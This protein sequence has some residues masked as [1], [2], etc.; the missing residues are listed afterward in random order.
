MNDINIVVERILFFYK[1]KVEK[2]S[3][4]TIMFWRVSLCYTII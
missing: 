1:L 4:S 3:F 2:V